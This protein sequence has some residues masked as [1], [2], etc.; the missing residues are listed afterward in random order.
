MLAGHPVIHKFLIHSSDTRKYIHVIAHLCAFIMPTE[1]WK[2]C[3][4]HAMSSWRN[5]RAF[6]S[7]FPIFCYIDLFLPL[8][9]PALFIYLASHRNTYNSQVWILWCFSYQMDKIVGKEGKTTTVHKIYAFAIRV[10]IKKSL[11]YLKISR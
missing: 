2:C 7:H 11:L 10:N 1:Q 6:H 4:G 9:Y 8:Y 3:E 5:F